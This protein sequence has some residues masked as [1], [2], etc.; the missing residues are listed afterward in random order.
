MALNDVVFVK[1]TS[2][3]GRPLAGQDHIS[4]FLVYNNTLPAGFTTTNNVLI[5]YSI[6]DAVAAGIAQGSGTTG[7]YWY[8][9][10]EFFKMQPK[11]VLYFGI[12]PVPAS[13]YD[14]AE[15]VTLQNFASG[16]I[17][18]AGIY[19]TITFATSQL[20]AIQTQ[21][22]ALEA[23]H[24][25][26]QV[27]YA[28]DISG[29]TNLGTLTDLTTLNA[30]RVTLVISQDG[31]GAGAALY[32]STAK[33]ITTI[34][35]ALGAVASASVH[36]CIGWP[37]KFPA[38]DGVENDTLAFANGTLFRTLSYSL[39]STLDSYGYLF[40]LK[41]QDYDGSYYNNSYTAVTATSDYRTIE[42]NRTYDK[43][44]RGV[45]AAMVPY[46]AAPIYVN[47]A[48]GTLSEDTIK[49][50]EGL[51]NQPITQM[52][53]DGELSG[54]KVVINPAQNVLSTSKLTLTLLNVPV[55]VARQI[56]VNVGF[57]TKLS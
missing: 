5:F 46:I 24:K 34:G 26:L 25:P 2:G 55:G 21:A 47:P 14:F 12:F 56:Q 49:F 20:T 40:L 48:D 37:L 23:Q 16:K 6:S 30:P 22:A 1:S 53:A 15:L 4:G 39:L 3:L 9:I 35:N 17:R 36:E 45:R 44:I 50:F 38:S 32:T 43:A 19:C 54:H 31:A 18:Q 42:N 57:T 28:A 29:V 51:A 27:L 11:G 13:T 52:E 10:N 8:H 33:S 41:I 7:V